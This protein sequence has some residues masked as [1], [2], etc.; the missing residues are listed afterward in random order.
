MT[1][2]EMLRKEHP[3]KCKDSYL[4]GCAGCPGD[5]YPGAPEEDQP[6]CCYNS[7][8]GDYNCARCWGMEV[9]K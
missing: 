5:Y 2:R 8:T 1:Y 9:K 6:N 7:S 4:G 3:E